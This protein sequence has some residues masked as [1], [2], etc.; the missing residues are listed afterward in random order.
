MTREEILKDMEKTAGYMKY[1]VEQLSKCNNENE[2]T[3]KKQGE[4]VKRKKEIKQIV[5]N[6]IY[7]IGIPTHIKGYRY[8]NEAIVM[9]LENDE[10]HWGEITQSL[11]QKIAEKCQ[12]TPT[13]VENDIRNAMKRGNSEKLKEIFVKSSEKK[14]YQKEQIILISEYIRLHYLQ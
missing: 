4:T 9:F 14:R 10:T 1:L 11:Y 3:S 12:S 6:F 13:K 2:S 7:Q 8:L 5:A